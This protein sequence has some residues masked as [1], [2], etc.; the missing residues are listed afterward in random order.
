MYNESKKVKEINTTLI[1]VFLILIII[2]AKIIRYTVMKQSLVDYTQG[3]GWLES[4]KSG[5]N[6]F[7]FNIMAGSSAA[8]ENSKFFFQI[9][10]FLGLTT[11]YDYEIL[12][13]IIWNLLLV[14]IIVKLKPKI[15]I[16]EF[17]FL[18]MAIAVL[19]IWDFC[20]SKE[21]LQ[22]LL[23][24]IIFAI[25]TI[26]TKNDKF[27]FAISLFIIF[28]SCFIYRNYY[29]GIILFALANYILFEKIIL[30]VKK[31]KIKHI[32]LVMTVYGLLFSLIL[33]LSKTL[34]PD[35]YQQLTYLNTNSTT[36]KTDISGIFNST[37]LFLGSIDY[38][39]LII[40]LL[41]P[42]ELIN[43]GVKYCLYIIYQLLISVFLIKSILKMKSNSKTVN[44]AIFL[45]LGYLLVSALF[46]P[47]FGSWV[48]HE[49]TTLPLLLIAIGMTK[50]G[51]EKK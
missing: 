25:M 21:P 18:C 33:T 44:Y 46:E 9:F 27:K 45:F 14:G 12:I 10:R 2:F 20:L 7:I 41:F 3:F 8:T 50:K 26:K 47:D 32:I 29:I 6:N 40:R 13:T 30:K 38:I 15:T 28:L 16:P 11:F 48:R 31:I 22:M 37:N 17:I 19:N 49:A 5:K 39:L 42:I 23:F 1:L 4:M 35:I 43:F 36:A 24:T 51:T 34:A